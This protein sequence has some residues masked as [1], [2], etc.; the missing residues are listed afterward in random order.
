L[1]VDRRR[2][3]PALTAD[4]TLDHAPRAWRQWIRFGSPRLPQLR[5]RVVSTRVRPTAAQLPEAGSKDDVILRRLYQH[6]DG[7]K[8][9]FELLA[10]RIA[11]L[12]LGG[13]GSTYRAGWISRGAGDGGADFISRL[14][15]GDGRCTVPIVV[16][17][18]AKCIAPESSISAE[19]LARVVARLRRGWI[20]VFVT[21]GTISRPA[22]LEM[23]DDQYPVLLISGTD[24]AT[25]AQRLAQQA[26]AGNLDALLQD[27]TDNYPAAVS[28]RRPEEILVD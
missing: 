16:L 22:Q 11:G 4:R 26:H 9:A 28:A 18:Q 7:R 5:R 6:F 1:A 3:N 17:G 20:G 27:V 8:H 21:T 10:S 15:V 25:Y 12:V 14:D 13:R 2:R 23:I 19:Q 24:L